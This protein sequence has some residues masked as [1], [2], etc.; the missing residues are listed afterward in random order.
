MGTRVRVPPGSIEEQQL[1]D[2]LGALSEELLVCAV[3]PWRR[4]DLDVEV[5]RRDL[6]EDLVPVIPGGALEVRS[7]HRFASGGGDAGVVDRGP[8][9]PKPLHLSRGEQVNGG[10]V[11][12]PFTA[13]EVRKEQPGRAC[14]R[15]FQEEVFTPSRPE[16]AHG[17][18]GGRVDGVAAVEVVRQ[19]IQSGRPNCEV[20]NQITR[21]TGSPRRDVVPVFAACCKRVLAGVDYRLYKDVA[22]VL[23]GSFG[24]CRPAEDFPGRLDHTFTLTVGKPYTSF[25]FGQH[26]DVR[27]D[28]RSGWH[29]RAGDLAK[30]N[31]RGL[32]AV[33]RTWLG[34]ACR[35]L[36]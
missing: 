7:Q 30:R 28:G 35:N 15:P 5:E 6:L 8:V 16:P 3:A 34:P 36:R 13:A 19:R 24:Q 26:Q 31:G 12:D 2:V 10:D 32:G 4:R 18:G 21:A 17:R 29:R 9:P 22:P 23:G 14:S 11:V 20:A 33:R 27:C 25:V 1:D